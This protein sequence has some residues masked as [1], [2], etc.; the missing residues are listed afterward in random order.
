MEYGAAIIQ[1]IESS[2]AMV[3]VLSEHSNDSHFVRKEVERAVSKAKPVLPVRIREV[4]PSGSLEFFI[5]S[6]QWVDA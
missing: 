3:L 4:N 6:A 5:S 2:R 1:G